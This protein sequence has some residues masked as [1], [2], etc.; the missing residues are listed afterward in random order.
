MTEDELDDLL[1]YYGL[2]A[3]LREVVDL[4]RLAADM[5]SKGL[6]PNPGVTHSDEG[7]GR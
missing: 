2:P 6:L 4:L 1:F 3:D 7:L 5:A